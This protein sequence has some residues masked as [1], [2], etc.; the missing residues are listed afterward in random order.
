[1]AE[2]L[3]PY[4]RKCAGCTTQ[5]LDYSLQ[6]ENKKK[7][8]LDGTRIN[9]AEVFSAEPYYYRNR[10]EFF[11][12]EKSLCLRGKKSELVQI[13][14]CVIAEEKIYG[15]MKE[16]NRFFQEKDDFHG[17]V[18]R[19]TKQSSS[20]S[21]TLKS[22]FSEEI[23]DTIKEFS[24]IT[25]A[26]KVIITFIS[27]FDEFYSDN[28][29]VIKG[30]EYL[31]EELL[32]RRFKFSIQGF[33]QNN[34]IMAEKMQKYVSGLLEKYTTQ[35]AE[36]LDLYSGV[37]TFG[38]INGDKFEKVT[39]VESFAPAVELAKK[40]MIENKIKNGQAYALTGEQIGRIKFNP[41]LYVI[42]DPPRVGM[43]QRS[44]AELNRL[45]PHL[46]VY[47]SCNVEQ[48]KKDLLKFK[49]YVVKSAAL[50]DLFP[51]TNHSEAVVELVLTTKEDLKK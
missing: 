42:T 32:G 11:W 27:S 50:F 20:L 43:E 36:L 13:D 33:F 38:I 44:I 25:T 23:V 12:K 39:L 29:I 30:E 5:H 40:N 21:F 34:T 47:V 1:M 14:R 9:E 8:I 49:N 51:Q 37:G 31:E 6:L 16:I 28:Y 19:V 18:I 4:F 24:T 45:K 10:M 35:K 41:D 48:L 7:K 22:G 46:I 26:E 2:P 17:V 3:C 15:L